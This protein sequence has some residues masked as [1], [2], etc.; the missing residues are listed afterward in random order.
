MEQSIAW[1]NAVSQF[2][3]AAKILKL[4]ESVIELLTQPKRII[5]VSIPIKMDDKSLKTF[6]GFRVQF[7]D[8]RGPTKGGIRYHHE[9]DM[10]EVK[11]LAFLMTW[12]NTIVDIPFGGAKGGIICNPKE[13]SEA[14]LERLSR[15]YIQAMYQFI[16][17]EKDI[18][19]PDVYTTPQIMAWMMDEYHKFQGHNV[20]GMI[21]GKPI[22]L[23]GSKGRDI[24]T[25][26]GGTFVLEEAL[27][28]MKLQKPTIAIQGFGNA[29]RT[30]AKLLSDKGY[31]IVAVSDS[32]GGVYNEKG[33][34]LKAL[35]SHKDKTSS[36]K[37]FKDAK[38]I[39]N[40]KLLEIEC[41][42]LIPAA[43]GNQIRK[44]NAQKIK[45]KIILEL[46]NGPVTSEARELLFKKGIMSIPDILANAG[47]VTVSYFEWVQNNTGDSW[48]HEEV[49]ARLK[50]KMVEAFDS[51][52]EVYEEENID[53]GL[54]AQ[55]LAIKRMVRVMELRGIY[56][57]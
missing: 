2:N 53:M 5:H 31:K 6:Q 30:A 10:E 24:A 19:A 40:E 28:K 52:Y 18:P 22:E 43:L 4:N 9:V 45:A 14:E 55:I 42:V 56:K 26:L 8:M 17:P 16:G 57:K 32:H 48:T 25:A 38:N 39:S 20:F 37:D 46:A 35:M 51:V 23:G 21:T 13:L 12:K 29:G 1:N 44:D 47:G 50:D 54:A 15:G 36:V 7:N 49:Y 27:Q 41:D 34:D 33:L 3:K 11:A